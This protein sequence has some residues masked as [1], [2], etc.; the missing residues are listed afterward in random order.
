MSP[1]SSS[2]S[3]VRWCAASGRPFY[4]AIRVSQCVLSASG[5]LHLPGQY[6]LDSAGVDLS[7]LRPPGDGSQGT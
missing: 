6:V 4:A 2:P 7:G 5:R 3:G 1:S